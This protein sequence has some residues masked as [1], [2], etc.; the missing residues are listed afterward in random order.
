MVRVTGIS[1]LSMVASIRFYWV[2]SFSP[3]FVVDEIAVAFV[4]KERVT[5]THD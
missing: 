1:F 4:Q 5:R 2:G 3:F